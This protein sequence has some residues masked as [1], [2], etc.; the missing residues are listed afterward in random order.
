M[1]RRFAVSICRN[2]GHRVRSASRATVGMTEREYCAAT[3]RDGRGGSRAGRSCCSSRARSGPWL[4]K[5]RF[6]RIVLNRGDYIVRRRAP[7][8][9][10]IRPNRC[11]ARATRRR[12]RCASWQVRRRGVDRITGGI[13]RKHDRTHRARQTISLTRRALVTSRA[14]WCAR[15]VRRFGA[16]PVRATW[17][18]APN[19]ALQLK[20]PV[21][22]PWNRDRRGG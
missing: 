10:A 8:G 21:W 9:R 5:I 15:L 19:Q 7:S 18:I 13:R 12:P 6:P 22:R 3:C 2:R 4:T 1:T 14:C 17:E 16:R 11:S 20:W